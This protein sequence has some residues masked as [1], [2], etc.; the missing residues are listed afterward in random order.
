M[1]K[2]LLTFLFVIVFICVGVSVASAKNSSAPGNSVAV[3]K[4]LSPAR[5]ISNKIKG[6]KSKC[7]VVP[8]AAQLDALLEANFFYEIAC[9]S[10]GYQVGCSPG[11]EAYLL[12]TASIYEL[13]L[14]WNGYSIDK[15]KDRHKRQG[16]NV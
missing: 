5:T 15:T 7:A 2:H 16:S 13:C 6:L 11:D 4:S 1:K 8:C 14:W 9:A 12:Q 3:S 10:G